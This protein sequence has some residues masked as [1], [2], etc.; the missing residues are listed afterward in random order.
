MTP[1]KMLIPDGRPCHGSSFVRLAAFSKTVLSEP[2]MGAAF[3]IVSFII[4]QILVVAMHMQTTRMWAGISEVQRA[5]DLYRE[6]YVEDKGYLRVA[7]AIEGCQKLYKSDGGR[8]SHLEINEY[9][10][11]FSDLGLFINRGLLSEELV[12][13]FFW[14]VYHRGIRIP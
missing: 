10:G 5:R 8:F 12:G 7:N 6:F 13:H 11:F 4:A 3:L 9:L 14:R 2:W 1:P